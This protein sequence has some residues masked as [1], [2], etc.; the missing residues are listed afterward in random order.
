MPGSP[1]NCGPMT[2]PRF[3]TTEDAFLGGQLRLRQPASGHRAGHDALLLAAATPAVA[4]QRVVEFGAGVGVAGLSVARRAG[5]ALWLV[6]IDPW[7]ADLARA[8]A[9][10]NAIDADVVTLDVTAAAAAFAAAGLPPD[11]ADVV[12]MNP[13]FHDAARHRPS[14]DPGRAAAHLATADTPQDWVH[15]ARRV[16]KPS[17]VLTLIWRADGLAEILATLGRG[18]GGIVVLPVH[19]DASAPAIRVIVRAVKASR[20]PTEIWPGLTLRDA[21]GAADP[22]IGQVLAGKAVLPLAM[23]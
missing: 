9:A 23:R 6:E 14:P 1:T 3:A 5:I 12:L 8:N 22:Y 2:D 21:A 20:A 17:G 18:F 16:L 13:P 10:A 15:A 11:S 4:G 19:G 7:L